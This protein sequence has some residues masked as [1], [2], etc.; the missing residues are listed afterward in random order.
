M[1]QSTRG[2]WS[3]A[4]EPGGQRAR[5]RNMSVL[6]PSIESLWF[7]FTKKTFAAFY[8][9]RNGQETIIFSGKSH[10]SKISLKSFFS[11]EIISAVSSRKRKEQ[12]T[13]KFGSKYSKITFSDS[14]MLLLQNIFCIF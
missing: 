9:K 11:K 2:K 10:Y 6:I 4:F 13:I 7:P 1:C 12:D 14:P 5:V 3:R 8:A